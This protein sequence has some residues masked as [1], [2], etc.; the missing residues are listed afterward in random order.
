MEAEAHRFETHLGR[1]SLYLENGFAWLRDTKLADGVV[2]FDIAFKR[3]RGF[4]GAVWR[5]LD[6]ANTSS[7]TCARTSPETRTRPST[8]R[9]FTG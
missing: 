6:T 8:R 5:M 7:S 1:P 3:D 4:S 9:P 2:E